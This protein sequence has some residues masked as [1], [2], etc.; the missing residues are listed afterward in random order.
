MAKALEIAGSA[1]FG[2]AAKNRSQALGAKAELA[3]HA[4]DRLLA[5]FELVP[6]V[7]ERGGRGLVRPVL[8]VRAA[9]PHHQGV[10]AAAAVVIHLVHH[11]L[12]DEQPAAVLPVGGNGGGWL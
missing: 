10:V 4:A 11:R 9:F 8:L 2:T 3:S 7:L 6:E 5:A 12:D 1:E